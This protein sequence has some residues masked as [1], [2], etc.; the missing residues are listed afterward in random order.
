M[1]LV[2]TP[3]KLAAILNISAHIVKEKK[4]N[5]KKKRRIRQKYNGTKRQSWQYEEDSKMVWKLWGR[6]GG[7][8]ASF[9]LKEFELCFQKVWSEE[10]KHTFIILKA[11]F[12]QHKKCNGNLALCVV[13]HRWV[14]LR[15]SNGQWLCTVNRADPGSNPVI[16]KLQKRR[17]WRK[18]GRKRLQLYPTAKSRATVIRWDKAIDIQEK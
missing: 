3:V 14:T 2:G 9:E 8:E 17:K 12:Q 4:N 1:C 10:S 6:E 16:G 5:Y 11:H 13:N 15:T 18:R 7:D